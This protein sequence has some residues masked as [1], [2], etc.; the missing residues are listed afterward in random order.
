[1]YKVSILCNLDITSWT[2]RTTPCIA[3]TS[4]ATDGVKRHTH[5]AVKQSFTLGKPQKKSF[6]TSPPPPRAQWPSKLFFSLLFSSKIAENRFH[7]K[8]SHIQ[9]FLYLGDQ[10]YQPPPQKKTLKIKYALFQIGN[11]IKKVIFLSGQA[12]TPLLVSGLLK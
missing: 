9:T 2:Y 3:G 4:S 1:M 10:R 8:K 6:L 5:I 11:K 12:L 7:P